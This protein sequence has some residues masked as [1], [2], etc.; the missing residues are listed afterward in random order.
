VIIE[1]NSYF[2]PS[3]FRIPTRGESPTATSGAS[4]LAMVELAKSKGYELAI[5]TGNC[6]F[7]R[8]EL[9]HALAIDPAAWQD[10]FDDRWLEAGR[11]TGL[12]SLTRRL[13]RRLRRPRA[14]D[15]PV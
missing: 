11:T 13:G 1:V 7:V 2:P 9:A 14:K 12:S 4:F 10:L 6:V 15:G 8:Q 5:H 3:I